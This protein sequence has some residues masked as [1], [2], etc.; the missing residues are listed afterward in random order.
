MDPIITLATPAAILAVVQLAKDLGLG[1]KASLVAAVRACERASQAAGF[2]THGLRR[3]WAV[4][5]YHHYVAHGND[6]KAALRLLSGDLGH[7][8]GR[9]RWCFNNY[10][11]GAL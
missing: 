5:Q 3:G 6:E 7:G 1:G 8:D 10:L 4:T 9:G 2:E 11:R